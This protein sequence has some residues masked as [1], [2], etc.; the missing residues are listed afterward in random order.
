MREIK[1]RAYSIRDQEYCGECLYSSNVDQ[2]IFPINGELS[3]SLKRKAENYIVEQYT[4]LNCLNNIEVYEG[5]KFDFDGKA[6]FV[7]YIEDRARFVLTTGK[8]FDSKNCMDLDH[9]I[10]FGKYV[11]GNIHD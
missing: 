6:F 11:I 2:I 8:G 1:F 5:D 10:I 7:Q 4:G 9:D 3:C